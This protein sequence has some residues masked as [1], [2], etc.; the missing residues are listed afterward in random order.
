MSR[1]SATS[2]G[3]R[4]LWPVHSSADDLLNSKKFVCN[5]SSV[6]PDRRSVYC[7]LVHSSVKQYNVRKSADAAEKAD[8]GE[9]W[10]QSS[11]S[12]YSP[13]IVGRTYSPG[14]CPSPNVVPQAHARAGTCTAGLSCL[15]AGSGPLFQDFVP[16]HI[17]PELVARPLNLCEHT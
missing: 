13:Q 16:L 2:S 4:I 1:I 12:G 17:I 8:A 5:A 9:L 11:K 6:T 3:A 7:T 15:I 14:L 10:L